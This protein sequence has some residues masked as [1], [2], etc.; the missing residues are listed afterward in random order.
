ME[1]WFE[2]TDQF[3]K[4]NYSGGHHVPD[5]RDLG[6]IFRKLEQSAIAISGSLGSSSSRNV[7]IHKPA[8]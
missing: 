8:P 7:S 6:A 5:S 2:A 1:Q 3:E 4:F